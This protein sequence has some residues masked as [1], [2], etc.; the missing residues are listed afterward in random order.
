MSAL[1]II[2]KATSEF[3]FYAEVSLR[4]TVA[5]A[6]V[7]MS[8][9]FARARENPGPPPTQQEGQ[10]LDQSESSKA[11]YTD[12][13]GI[14]VPVSLTHPGRSF[15]DSDSFPT[16]PAIGERL[17]NFELPNQHGEIVDFHKARKGKR[18]VVT[19]N[20]SAAW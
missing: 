4:T 1:F 17:P 12:E 14:F 11:E 10:P 15:P 20:R 7:I 19:F 13:F 2:R 6:V 5:I 9:T 8:C 16:G 18:A 3:L